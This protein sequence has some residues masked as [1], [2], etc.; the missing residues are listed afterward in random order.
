[1]WGGILPSWGV[2]CL[3]GVMLEYPAVLAIGSQVSGTASPFPPLQREDAAGVSQT[4]APVLHEEGLFVGPL[5][6]DNSQHV[7]PGGCRHENFLWYHLAV[8]RGWWS[9]SSYSQQLSC[10][11]FS[12]QSSSAIILL[13][14]GVGGQLVTSS[15]CSQALGGQVRARSLEG[16][17]RNAFGKARRK[18]IMIYSL[19]KPRDTTAAAPCPTL[20]RLHRG[21]TPRRQ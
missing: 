4:P 11:S 13:W 20:R 5:P 3:L 10:S 8:V 7:V 2:S 12:Q 18:F 21:R 9:A 19:G 6:T 1:M 17:F 15:C 14:S 16:P